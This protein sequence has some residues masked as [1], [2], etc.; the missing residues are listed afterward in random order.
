M[1]ADIDAA[2]VQAHH[3]Q[4]GREAFLKL[5]HQ[6]LDY[7]EHQRAQAKQASGVPA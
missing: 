1:T 2:V 5:V 4:I 7:F 6:R 3:L